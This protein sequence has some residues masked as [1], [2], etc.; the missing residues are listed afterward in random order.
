MYIYCKKERSPAKNGPAHIY[1]YVYA[2]AREFFPIY[3][4]YI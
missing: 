4:R 2:C 3:S 1:I